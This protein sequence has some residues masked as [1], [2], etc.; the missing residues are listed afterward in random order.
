MQ[1]H[2]AQVAAAVVAVETIS[3]A[4]RVEQVAANR[5]IERA[6]DG[7]VLRMRG[8]QMFCQDPKLR[9]GAAVVE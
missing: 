5:R 7:R 1:D 6:P 4:I 2:P 8:R 3:I 9:R